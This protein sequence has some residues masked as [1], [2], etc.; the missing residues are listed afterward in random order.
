SKTT[1][2]SERIR[3]G[4]SFKNLETSTTS[5]FRRDT[6]RGGDDPHL[7]RWEQKIARLDREIHQIHEA[8]AGHDVPEHASQR[9]LVLTAE[10]YAARTH[11]EEDETYQRQE[12]QQE[13]PATAA[14]FCGSARSHVEAYEIYRRQEQ[15]EQRRAA[16]PGEEEGAA[17]AE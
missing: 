7:E 10:L 2:L 15:E 8:H 12:Q 1:G 9:I 14:E 11:V 5:E 16:A 17:N 3:P 13:D 6:P 4:N